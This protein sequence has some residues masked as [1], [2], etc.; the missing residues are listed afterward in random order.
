M[1]REQPHQFHYIKPTRGSSPSLVPPKAQRP[2]GLQTSRLTKVCQIGD[3]PAEDLDQ[4]AVSGP[5][6]KKNIHRKAHINDDLEETSGA[7]PTLRK[8]T[9]PHQPMS[10]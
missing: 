2:K 4:G 9:K 3:F 1:F 8:A 6:G 7:G 10:P 5:K